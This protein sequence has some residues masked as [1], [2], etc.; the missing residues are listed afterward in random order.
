MLNRKL[1]LAAFVIV[2]ISL[3]AFFL[4]QNKS[5]KDSQQ[6]PTPTPLSKKEVLVGRS[7]TPGRALPI[8]IAEKKGFFDKQNLNIKSQSFTR[9]Y[10][11]ALIAG[12]LDIVND[13]AATFLAA[14]IEGA[15]VKMIG[16][17]LQIDPHFIIGAPTVNK[18]NIRRVPINR[19][20]G[21][22]YYMALNAL[23]QMGVDTSKINFVISGSD[24]GKY[25]LL[26]QKKIDIVPIQA[27]TE[28]L[29]ITKELIKDNYKVLF[30][31]TDDPNAYFP[32]GVFTR[33]D[34]LKNNP[35]TVK[36]V[37]VALKEAMEYAKTNKAD[38]VKI[39]MDEYN[40]KED[41]ADFV[42]QNFLTSIKQIDLK[43]RVE[44]IKTLLQDMAVENKKALQYDPVQFVDP[45]YAPQ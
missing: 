30:N 39:L 6:T 29:R 25:P 2:V 42:Y 21:E 40:M 38:T 34:Y 43:P 20:G 33:G 15:D 32:I 37:L 24:E 16:V 13:G 28:Y 27:N 36:S 3:G 14:A 12:K 22:G 1:S 4:L 45:T 31:V 41:E 44:F 8:L 26:L 7:V 19:L 18:D 11:E 10:Q 9:G 23:R 17:T 35:E 5:T